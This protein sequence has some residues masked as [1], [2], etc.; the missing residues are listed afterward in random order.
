MT[1]GG[2]VR[3]RRRRPGPAAAV[4]VLALLTGLVGT[5]STAA[6]AAAHQRPDKGKVWVPPNTPVG[7]DSPSVSGSDLTVTPLPGSS[8]LPPGPAPT[9]ARPVVSG[10]ATV[11]LGADGAEA[12]AARAAG[13]GASPASAG[14]TPARAGDLPVLLLPEDGHDRA[15]RTVAVEVTGTDRGRAAGMAGPLLAL[16]DADTPAGR[17]GSPEDL[18]TGSAENSLAGTP[19]ADGAPAGR[20]VRVTVD[21]AGLQGAAWADRAQL[22]ALPACALTEPERAEC[23]TRT[24]VDAVADVRSATLTATVTLPTA[25]PAATGTEGKAAGTSDARSGGTAPGAAPLVLAAEPT[26]AGSGG[27]YAAT[28]LAPSMAWNAGSNAGNFLYSYPVDVPPALG[29]EAPSVS[30]SYNSATVDGRSS[31]TN[32]QSSWIGDGWDYEPGYIERSYRPCDKAGITGSADLCWAGQ[33]ASLALGGHSGAL[34]RDDTTGV[35]HLQGDDGSKIEQLSG[36]PNG[37]NGGEYWRVTTSD[38]V[39]YYF[40]RNH[41]PGG[42]GTDPATDSA[43]GVPVYAP[44]NGDPCHTAAAGKGSWCTMGWRWQL[45]YVVDPH[46]NLTTYAYATETNHYSRGAGQNNGTGA[47]TPYQRAGHPKQ[48]SYGQRLPE[49]IAARGAA[50]PAA[51]IDFGTAERCAPS[52]AVTC[53]ESERTSANAAFWPDVPVDQQCGASGSCANRGPSFF[54][55]KRLTTITTSVLSGPA[56]TTVDT[57][58]LDQSFYDPGDG[59]AKTLWLGSV[60]RTGSNGRPAQSLPAVTFSAIGLANRVDG[61]VPA[62]PMFV[63]PRISRIDTETGGRINVNYS[64]PACSRVENRMPASEDSNTLACMPV[65]WYKPGSSTPVADWFNKP[66]VTSV[67]EQDAVTGAAAV[68]T[69]EYS[70]HGGAAW[71]RNDAEY[72]DPK[73]RT[74]DGFRGYEAVTTTTGSGY[75][76]EAP[77]TQQ[78]VTYLRGMDGDLKADGTKR[79]VSVTSPLGGTV[80]DS[81]W[82]AGSTV[83][84][85]A[86][87]QANGTVQSVKGSVFSAQ[88][89]TATQAR[90]GDIPFRYARYPASQVTAIAKARLADGSWRTTTT[91]STSD[92]AN[93]NRLLHVA[94]KGDS[95]AAT[96][97]TCTTNSYAT[98]TNPMLRQLI[99]QSVHTAAPC[100]TPAAPAN[101]ISAVRTLFDGKPYG[102]AGDLGDHTSSLVLE[103]FDGNAPVYLLQ[104]T[105]E[106]D[107]YG[108]PVRTATTDGS[109][110]DKDGNRTGGPTTEPAVTLIANTP[111]SGALPTRITTTG[112]LGGWTTSVDFDPGRGQALV[113]TDAN[114]RTTT[115]QHDAL[116]R[117][118][119]VWNPDR[120]TTGKAGTKYSYSLNGTTGPSVVMTEWLQGNAQTYSSKTELFD[121]LGR[122]RQTQ[123]TSDSKPTGRLIT[124]T[125]Y[126]SHGWAVKVSSPYYEASSLPGRNLF[127]PG[128]DSQVPAQNW[129]SYDGMGR[130]VR[131]EFRFFANPQW[132]TVTTYPGAD[133]TDVTPPQ[134]ESPATAVTD[135]RGLR[136]ALWQYR[137]ATPTGNPADADVTTYRYT[138]AGQ[139]AGHTDRAGNTWTYRYDVR[140]RQIA[141]DDP[142]TGTSTVGYDANSRVERTT[143]ARGRTIVTTYDVLGRRT[144]EYSDSVAPANQL[145]GFTYD[146]LAKGQ[147]TSST[148]YTAGADGPAYTKTITGYDTAYRPLGTTVTIPSTEGA[149]AG[150]YTTATTY[151]PVTGA[152]ASLGV[153]AAGGLPAETLTYSY[154]DTGLLTGAMSDEQTLVQAVA[155]DALGRPVRTT[156]GDYGTQVVSTQQYDWSTGRVINSFTDKQTGTVPVSKSSYTYTA[157]GRLTSVS[158]LQNATATDTQCFTYDHLGRL[159][160]AWSDTG[161]V[162]TAADWTDTTGVKHGTGGGTTVPG[163][164]G[165]DNASGPAASAGGRTVG[166]PSPYWQSYTYD[167]TGNRKS[168]TRHDPTGDSS[169]DTV[170][171]QT[172]GAAGLVNTPTTA[173]DTGGGTGGPHALLSSTT[174]SPTGTRTDRYQYDAAGDTTAVTGTGGTT[175]LGWDGQGKLTTLARTEQAS[176]NEYVYDA[177]GNLL[178]RR[179][180]GTTTLLLAT[181]QLTLDT[182]SGSMSTV[183]YIGAPGGLSLTRVT[184]PIGGGSLFVQAADPHGTN[185]VQIACDPGQTVTRRPTDPFGNT[186]GTAPSPDSWAGSKGFVGGAQDDA[187]GLTILGARHYEPATGRFISP[188][189]L[190]DQADPQQWNAYAYAGNDPVNHTDA[191]GLIIDDCKEGRCGGGHYSPRASEQVYPP[192]GFCATLQCA[193]QTSTWEYHQSDLKTQQ[194]IATTI[195]NGKGVGGT[196][197]KAKT[198]DSGC[199]YAMGMRYNCG[200]SGSTGSST[201]A[202]GD[203]PELL[204][205]SYPLNNPNARGCDTKVICGIVNTV[206]FASL[207][208]VGAPVCAAM[209][210]ACATLALEEVVST[211]ADMPIGLNPRA[212]AKG[213]AGDAL[214]GAARACKSFPAGTPVLLAD[215]STKP[216]E[217]LTEGDLVVATDPQTGESSAKPVTDTILTPDDTGF[218]DLT[219]VAGDGRGTAEPAVLT[220]T[221]HHPYWDVTTQRWT[222]AGD[223]AVGDELRTADGGTATVAATR[224]YRTAPRPAHNLTV[225]DLHTYY[226]LAGRTPVLVHN[227]GEYPKFSWFERNVLRKA[228]AAN[229][230]VAD[231]RGKTFRDVVPGDA[232]SDGKLAQARNLAEK[233]KLLDAIFRPKDGMYASLLSDGRTVDNGNHRLYYLFQQAERGEI[234]WDTPIYLYRLR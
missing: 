120:P 96:P 72:A 161:G 22:V 182:S 177:E 103:R 154:T 81:A 84:T 180:P 229:G 15:A 117:L 115:E 101:T 128:N 106:R 139:P 168:M 224:T 24:P 155:Y 169:Q 231:L 7:N 114:G 207:L 217:E 32:S 31:A 59:T 73:T 127:V 67:T 16:T 159:T 45:D 66:L 39:E 130:T 11:T 131:E 233:G 179:N 209:P 23:R 205:G 5:P 51:R 26:A 144:A 18:P 50:Q 160:Q 126:D 147:P 173:P 133:R 204:L 79:A 135:A 75:A 218:T 189:P 185:G 223:L 232:E 13:G 132:A 53:A 148:R 196:T 108:R 10:F 222:N 142:D 186:R 129:I 68:R 208:V 93:G 41:L 9:A 1:A 121:G 163:T 152:L 56:R 162:H 62:A 46:Q 190:I 30:L 156:V 226:V 102:Q 90:S 110:Y 54:S 64:P 40:G 116:G 228:P 227:C 98:S 202:K 158:D 74:W 195:S 80:V 122:L 118:T 125:A 214:T 149:L 178:L 203:Q 143:D 94:D 65:K 34:I 58:D 112:P 215:G 4:A 119:A 8:P 187:T 21:L 234:P 95:T 167:A 176:A 69:N 70:Y 42:D 27:S 2:P 124:D 153:P 37:L 36:A 199:I 83:A 219:L 183:R 212:G 25:V 49:Q 3:P 141:V 78:K 210:P 230:T 85:E 88:E 89:V 150:S 71:H 111:A 109:T 225:A 97:E 172:F 12:K 55:T 47:L 20:E 151:K 92:P 181:D 157:S 28:S 188:D 33:N 104:G 165:C 193:E 184:A 192:A 136:T 211:Q 63:R 216:I 137:T 105:V 174:T 48:I 197:T 76:G 52:G 14:T 138:A 113:H 134:G 221:Y 166:G 206:A 107:A 87:D 220:S 38:G 145:T 91:V 200:P 123:Q 164:G 17:T 213:A 82:L 6:W 57:W 99:A 35:W 171:T 201:P 191:S 175:T 170:T 100:G 61:L 146:T 29:G 194:Y 86:Y 77:K 43:L 198:K 140:G 19:A 44:N 60:T